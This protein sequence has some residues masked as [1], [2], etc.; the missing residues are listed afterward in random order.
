MYH[1]YFLL[2]IIS[3][4]HEQ[5]ESRMAYYDYEPIKSVCFQSPL[6]SGS[7][8]IISGMTNHLLIALPLRIDGDLPV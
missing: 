5:I 8:T 4:F 1:I 2:L 7:L 6:H 3:D